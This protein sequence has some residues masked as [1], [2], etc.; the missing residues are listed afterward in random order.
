MTTGLGGLV[1]GGRRSG[2][3]YQNRQQETGFAKDSSEGLDSKENFA[4]KGP[5]N[6]AASHE[7]PN[8]S[9]EGLWHRPG[10]R[11][12][13]KYL[14]LL[15]W[16]SAIDA[17]RAMRSGAELCGPSCPS[18][19]SRGRMRPQI[20]HSYC[21]SRK[22]PANYVAAPENF[23]SST[24]QSPKFPQHRIMKKESAEFMKKEVDTT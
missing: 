21:F 2:P 19:Y 24:T 4:K 10:S 3:Y 12:A 16:A 1:I 17:S 6:L 9:G 23:T 22:C 5:R 7:G 8:I 18:V 11:S 20:P 13:G 15:S 14:Q